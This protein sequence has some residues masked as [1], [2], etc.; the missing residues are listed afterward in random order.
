MDFD[1]STDQ[2]VHGTDRD[3]QPHGQLLARLW[4]LLLAGGAN[5][6]VSEL[7][8]HLFERCHAAAKLPSPCWFE[9]ITDYAAASFASHPWP[10]AWREELTELLGA[11]VTSGHL[12]LDAPIRG[13]TPDVLLATAVGQRPLTAAI[14]LGNLDASLAL[15]NAGA[16]VQI[17]FPGEAFADYTRRC[18]GLFTPAMIEQPCARPGIEMRTR[19][20]VLLARAAAMRAEA[21]GAPPLNDLQADRDRWMARFTGAAIEPQERASWHER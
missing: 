1:G 7:I 16:D 4:R 5:D 19:A 17:V 2:T 11:Y 20:A 15:V 3:G 14:R 6:T 12:R 21:A 18:F 13:A 9:G 10:Q 8:R